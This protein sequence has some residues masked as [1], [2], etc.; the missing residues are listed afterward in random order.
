MPSGERLAPV[1]GSVVTS[2]SDSDRVRIASFNLHAGVDGWGHPFDPVPPCQALDA[3]VLIFQENWIPDTGA[4]LARVIGDTLGYQVVQQPMARG[5]RA[6]PAAAGVG[7]GPTVRTRGDRATL[8]LDS[9]RPLA[10]PS[11]TSSRYREGAPGAVGIAVLTRLPLAEIAPI[12]LGRLRRDGAHRWAVG[13]TV[14]WGEQRLTVVG[15]H[16]SH[17]WAGSPR[18][19]RRLWRAL[20][21]LR[22]AGPV[23]LAGDMNMW[24]PPLVALLPGWRRAVKGPSWPA[25]R[26]HSQ[27][28]H[29]LVSGAVEVSRSGVAA[30]AGS[31]HRPV[32]IELSPPRYP[33]NR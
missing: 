26:P 10:V 16:M 17:I 6:L 24:G 11:S 12:D 19:L 29:I 13:V 21:P 15:T 4:G 9:E 28:D 33:P 8:F 30:A 22:E 18:Q 31:D 20:E 1:P 23:V 32:W 14:I 5:R 2:S 3:D 27:L 25:W 7:W